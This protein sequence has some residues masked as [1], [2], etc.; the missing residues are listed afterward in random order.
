MSGGQYANLPSASR[1]MNGVIGPY[2][3][4]PPS[5]SSSSCCN[6][7]SPSVT[8]LTYPQSPRNRIKTIVGG[9]QNSSNSSVNSRYLTP[10]I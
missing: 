1:P 10:T 4:P 9:Q 6:P 8:Y 5:S 3:N 2:E 7:L